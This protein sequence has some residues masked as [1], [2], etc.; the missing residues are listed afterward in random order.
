[1]SPHEMAQDA[2]LF[3]TTCL[4]SIVAQI[5]NDFGFNYIN[6]KC[7]HT[8]E[9]DD[10]VGLHAGNSHLDHKQR[11]IGAPSLDVWIGST[12]PFI[13]GCSNGVLP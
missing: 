3:V 12:Q 13:G 10:F 5:A 9:Q 7:L 1:M 4:K 8:F 6:P 2:H 11:C